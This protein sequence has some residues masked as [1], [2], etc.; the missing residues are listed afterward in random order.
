MEGQVPQP[1]KEER[2]EELMRLQ[3]DISHGKNLTLVGKR[4]R[5][6]VE[7]VEED[8]AVGRIETQAREIDGVTYIK[9]RAGKE[10]REGEF[11]EVEITAVHDYD[12]EAVCR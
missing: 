5:A 8:T 2:Y 1:V 10:L 4:V 9:G 7:A 12:L 11:V 6:L 3:A